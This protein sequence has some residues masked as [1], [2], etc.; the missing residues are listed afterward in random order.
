M[1]IAGMRGI[2]PIVDILSLGAVA[3]VR[4]NGERRFFQPWLLD[5][6]GDRGT[7]FG[8][9]LNK[10]SQGMP[11]SGKFDD[12]EWNARADPKWSS[13]GTRIVY[14]QRLTVSPECG[15]ANPLPCYPSTAQ[16][17]RIDRIMVATLKSRKPLQPKTIDPIP[18]IVQWA[19]PYVP[20][21][22]D[23]A[24][25]HIPEGNY[26]LKGQKTGSARVVI[27]ENAAGTG[28]KSVAVTYKDYSDDGLSKL[29]GHENVTSTP[30]TFSLAVL[31]WYSDIVQTGKVEGTKRT[32]ADGFHLAIDVLTN[33]FD[34]NGTLT[35]T[36]DGNVYTQP[37]N[38]A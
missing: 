33:I 20:G 13:D 23:P 17:G 14:F 1:F 38:G 25:S 8:Q 30:K 29:N 37:L 3:S 28:I 4:N 35:T 11:G 27:T 26:T 9:E 18:D 31:D 34:A 5:R 21:S 32:S 24:L 12:P 16:G 19:T 15:G 36:I 6:Y 10:A 7:Y 2:P 22:A